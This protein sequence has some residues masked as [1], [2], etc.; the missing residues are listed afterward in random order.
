MISAAEISAIIEARH[1]DPFA[2]LGP[3]ALPGGGT[4]LRAFI[5]G[6]ETLS[7]EAAGGTIPLTRLHP[8]GFFEGRVPGPGHRWLQAGAA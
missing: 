8:A 1:D 7:A 5:P 4:V 3:H 2:L 6:A